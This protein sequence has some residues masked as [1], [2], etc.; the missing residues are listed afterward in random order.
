MMDLSGW[1]RMVA[2][3]MFPGPPAA[4]GPARD[5]SIKE[6]GLSPRVRNLLTRNGYRTVGDIVG[7]EEWWEV[8]GRGFG[9]GSRAE[10]GLALGRLGI[11]WPPEED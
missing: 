2:S 1:A 5:A 3:A 8:G 10:L 7:R 6:L 4:T 9:A 11:A